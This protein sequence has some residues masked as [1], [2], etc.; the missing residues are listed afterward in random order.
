MTHKIW[1]DPTAAR[2]FG[3]TE[4]CRNFALS[5]FLWWGQREEN[6]GGKT[7]GHVSAQQMLCALTSASCLPAGFVSPPPALSSVTRPSSFSYCS[8]GIFCI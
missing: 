8:L 4:V 1:E 7:Q 2:D 5:L 3:C 6:A